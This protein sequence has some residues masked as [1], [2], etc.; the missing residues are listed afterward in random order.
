LTQWKKDK[1]YEKIKR[2]KSES[3]NTAKNLLCTLLLPEIRSLFYA[4][5]ARDY[6]DKPAIKKSNT[7]QRVREKL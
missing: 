2:S 5:S 6:Y 3:K 7:E 4:G 1:K